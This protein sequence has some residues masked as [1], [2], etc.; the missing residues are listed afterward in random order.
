MDLSTITC[1]LHGKVL[2]KYVPFKELCDC[3]EICIIL[4]WKYTV[5]NI[6]K[7]MTD[8]ELWLI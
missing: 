8:H 2:Y 4:I 3:F 7:Q 6:G 5:F 1:Y